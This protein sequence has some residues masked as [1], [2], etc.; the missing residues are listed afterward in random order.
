M[1]SL[2]H[3]EVQ[4]EIS[5][6]QSG[7]VKVSDLPGCDAVSM[8]CDSRR[9]EESGHVNMKAPLTPTQPHISQTSES[10]AKLLP[11]TQIVLHAQSRCH[12]QIRI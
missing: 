11:N 10:Y 12:I 4:N 9:F 5:V 6:R 7:V 3:D 1:P 2:L 8:M